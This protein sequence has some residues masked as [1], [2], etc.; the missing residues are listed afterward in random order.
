MAKIIKP[1][2]ELMRIAAC[3]F[4][5]YH[6]SY[7]YPET[8][9]SIAQ[10]SFSLFGAV[11]CC[12]SV[13]LFF[14]ISGALLLEKEESF[15]RLWKDKI[16]KTLAILIIFSFIYYMRLVLLY[17]REFDIIDFFKNLYSTN[18]NYSYW[19]LYAYIG[20]LICL[21]ILRK[22]AKCL[23]PVHYI[24]IF[25]ISISVI[26][27]IPSLEWFLLDKKFTINSNLV[28]SFFRTQAIVYP[29]LGYYMETQVDRSCIRKIL[30]IAWV[31]NIICI[32]ITCHMTYGHFLKT[33]KFTSHFY[34]SFV[35][36]NCVTIYLTF[37]YYFG[38]I[39]SAKFTKIICSIGG[40]TLGIYLLHLLLKE[41]LYFILDY[42]RITLKMN[43]IISVLIFDSIIFIS[44]YIITILLKR[45]PGISKI[46]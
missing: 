21:P 41:H 19:Y 20:Y 40:A 10:I 14:M 7:I 45:I 5:I 4:V 16:L 29:L 34:M 24:Y 38:I 15:K 39:G 32:L 28:N 31:T 12:F 43:N 8:P 35:I 27:I 23:E 42:F 1:H 37:K 6:H 3:F 46:I 17:N 26:G 22:V 11:F 9:A 18:W 33:G 25:T 44:C 30:P 13:G 2:L 36:I